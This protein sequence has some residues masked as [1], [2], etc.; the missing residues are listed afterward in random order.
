[1]KTLIYGLLA[2][3]GLCGSNDGWA[4]NPPC[5]HESLAEA[6]GEAPAGTDHHHHSHRK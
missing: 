1:M 6:W 3:C 5:N 4:S 2:L